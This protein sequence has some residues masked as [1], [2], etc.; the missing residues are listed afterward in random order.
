MNKP[1]LSIVIANYNYGRFLEEAI[2]SVLSQ[3][4]NDYELIIV[5]GGST[6]NSVEIIKKYEDKIAWWVSEKDKGQS[7]AFNKGFA[8]AKGKFG[9]WLNADDILMPNAISVVVD[10]IKK[11]PKAEWVCGS[12]VF[13]DAHLNIKWCSRCVKTF[14]V[15]QKKIPWYSI[16]G[17]SSFFLLKNLNKVGGF[18]LD[19]HYTMDT[20]LWRRFI[21]NGVKLHY[22]KNYIWCFR[23]HEES[24]TSHKFLTGRGSN[25]FATEGQVMNLRYGITSFKN[26]VASY[27][28]RFARLI[29]GT[30]LHG[31]L[32]TR[33]YRGQP[34][35]SVWR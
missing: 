1:L 29:S 8:Q 33:R 3:S 34:I 13:V 27:L 32:D 24:K 19:L 35:N 10:Y 6:D 31:Y 25:S 21:K 2:Q 12:S 7:D 23:V 26:K 20:D 14:N 17:P 4:C 30:Y 28:N 9:C 11:N 5:D 15:F 16:N 18:D 22:V